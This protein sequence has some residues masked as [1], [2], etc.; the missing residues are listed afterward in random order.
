LIPPEC[1]AVLS[2]RHGSVGNIPL[3]GFG[4]TVEEAVEFARL[5]CSVLKIKI[6]SDPG[7][8][9]DQAQMLEW[10]CDRIGEL[11]AALRGFGSTETDH[12]KIAYY[13]DANGRYDS[14]ARIQRLLDHCARI[15]ALEQI[16][17]LEEPFP[18][19]SDQDVSA[20]PVRVAADESAHSVADVIARID[21]GCRAIALKPIAKTLSSSLRMA[22]EAHRRGVPCFCA[23]L[24]VN[25]ILVDWNKNVAARLA[26]LP[27]LESGMFESNGAQNYTDWARLQSYHPIPGASWREPSNG[28]FTLDDSF[29]ATAGGIFTPSAHYRSLVS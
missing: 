24:T 29:Y 28:R 26:P 12:G 16:I 23:D 1:R 19:D 3:V 6:G 13:L 14:L 15:G 22:A 4:T 8:N 7:G 21:A 10:D 2:E 17:F 20:L 25:P 5:G 9:G 11:H 18:E 27:G